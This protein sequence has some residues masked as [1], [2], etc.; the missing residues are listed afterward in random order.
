MAL[1]APLPHWFVG[2]GSL[3][4]IRRAAARLRSALSTPLL[5]SKGGKAPRRPSEQVL[6]PDARQ[7]RDLQTI[8]AMP[9]SLPV[10]SAREAE[11]SESGSTSPRGRA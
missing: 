4:S 3:E 10:C 6:R 7:I 5:R 8:F 9:R 1:L 2:W 11:M